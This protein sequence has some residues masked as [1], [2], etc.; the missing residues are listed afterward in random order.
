MSCSNFRLIAISPTI[1]IVFEH[2]VL[3]RFRTCFTSCGAQF[4]FQKGLG[5]RTAV[6]V[7]RTIVDKIIAGGKTVINTSQYITH[8]AKVIIAD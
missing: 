1:S 3:D 8:R 4:G 5:C 7:V 2:C 6:Y